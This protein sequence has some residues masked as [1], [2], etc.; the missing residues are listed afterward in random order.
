MTTFNKDEVISNELSMAQNGLPNKFRLCAANGISP[1]K[2]IG[3]TYVETKLFGDMLSSWCPL[4]TSY[5]QSSDEAGRPTEDETDLTASG[6]QTRDN[7]S[8]DPANRNY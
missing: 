8:N 3:N 6:Q 5:T 1:A 4:Q 2:V 7:E